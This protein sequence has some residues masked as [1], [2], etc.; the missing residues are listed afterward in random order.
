T[1]FNSLKGEINGEQIETTVVTHTAAAPG[2]AALLVDYQAVDFT[3]LYNFLLASDEE[4]EIS[5]D[6]TRGY[7][8]LHF[9][10]R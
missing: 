1:D 6:L 10:V 7:R 9:W 2:G 5:L 3:G 8:Q 4:P